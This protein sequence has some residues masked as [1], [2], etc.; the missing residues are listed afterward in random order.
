[1]TAV[2]EAGALLRADLNPDLR[3]RI[4]ADNVDVELSATGGLLFIRIYE[5][6]VEPDPEL[7]RHGYGPVGD[8]ST[9]DRLFEVC[10]PAPSM[11][12]GYAA[13]SFK[14]IDALLCELGL[15]SWVAEIVTDAA[16]IGL[17]MVADR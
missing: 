2:V 6:I 10:V 3:P 7:V 1:M 11:R 13:R 16:A 9:G 14:H 4:A 12:H 17:R 15:E 8:E 5:I